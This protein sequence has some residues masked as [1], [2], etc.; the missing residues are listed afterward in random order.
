MDKEYSFNIKLYILNWTD[1]PFE[2]ANKDNRG[3]PS[4]ED[5]S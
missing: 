1:V 5:N 4:P 2:R 3:S